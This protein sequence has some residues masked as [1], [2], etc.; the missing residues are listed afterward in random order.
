MVW[1]RQKR[2]ILEGVNGLLWDKP[3]HRAF[4]PLGDDAVARVLMLTTT[5]ASKALPNLEL[6]K[7]MTVFAKDNRSF[8]PMMANHH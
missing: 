7:I 8:V 4:P 2:F 1:R 6:L 5:P 3:E